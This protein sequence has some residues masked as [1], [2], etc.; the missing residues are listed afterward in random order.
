MI[1]HPTLSPDTHT[2][3]EI[4]RLNARIKRIN[5]FKRILQSSTVD[6]NELRTISWNGIP[7]ELRPMA[8]QMLLG[9]LPANSDRRINTLERK[10]KE[11]VDGVKQA[12]V[13]GTAGLDQTIWHQISIDVPRTNPHIPLYGFETTQRSLERIL[14]VWAIRHPASGYVQGINDLVTPFFQVFLSA[15]IGIFHNNP[16]YS[17][18]FTNITTD[19]DVEIFNPNSLP[20]EVLD[21]VEADSFWCLTKLLDGIQDNYIHTQP[22]IQRQVT[23]LRD[24][25][26]RIDN[27]L[28]KHLAE[29]GVEFIQF[30]FRWMNCMLMR[31]LSVK[32]TIRMWDTY[33]VSL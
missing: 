1:Y 17:S 25:V 15:Y 9:Y 26:Q 16:S 12:F 28:T 20:K 8:W 11:F 22:G 29:Q 18:R 33:M 30:S 19:G 14:Y 2:E 31:E 10:R 7:D 3:A 13:R 24:L 6:L 27:S 4:E 5:K 32:N 21:V 23:G